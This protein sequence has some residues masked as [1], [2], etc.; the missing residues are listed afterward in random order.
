MVLGQ[1]N[2]RLVLVELPRSTAESLLGVTDQQLWRGELLTWR[3]PPAEVKRLNTHDDVHRVI[4][5]D[6]E[7]GLPVAAPG[8]RAEPH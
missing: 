5:L 1:L 8:Q 6:L 4:P 2:L 7:R 3:E